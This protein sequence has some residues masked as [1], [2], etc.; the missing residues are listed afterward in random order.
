MTWNLCGQDLE[1][2]EMRLG[3]FSENARMKNGRKI[4][5]QVFVDISDPSLC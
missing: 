3:G 5:R 4:Q 1:R 2:E